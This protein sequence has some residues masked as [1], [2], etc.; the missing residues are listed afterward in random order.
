[1][2]D[3]ISLHPFHFAGQNFSLGERWLWHEGH[4]LLA[5]LHFGKTTHFRAN[6]LPLPHASRHAD[7][8]TLANVLQDVNPEKVIFLGDLFHSRDNIETD[9]V[10]MLLG[11]FPATEF[12]LVRGNHDKFHDST[13]RWLNLHV[14]DEMNLGPFTLSHEPKPKSK[15][16]NIHGHLHPAARL[17]GVGKQS[18]RLPC[19]HFT[20]RSVCLPAFSVLS[21]TKTIK[22]KKGE[23]VVA[24]SGQSFLAFCP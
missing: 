11:L 20:S 8:Q 13:Y 22:P 18:I 5:D 14:C 24:I 4:L 7:Q 12:I 21:G 15:D 9:E 17:G 1:M 6:G 2:N 23:A 19:F 3:K 10:A 16:I